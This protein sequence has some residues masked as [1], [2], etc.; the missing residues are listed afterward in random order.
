MCLLPFEHAGAVLG[1]ED[2]EALMASDD[3]WYLSEMMNYPGVLND[4][5]SVLAK[6]NSA[7]K[8]NKPV[9]GH[10]PGLMGDAAARYISRGITDRP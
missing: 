9:D 5:P 1:P 3:I 10:A 8:H 7:K 2:V 6:I 4:D